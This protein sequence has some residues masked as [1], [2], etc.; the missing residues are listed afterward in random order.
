MPIR[1]NYIDV[2]SDGR[3]RLENSTPITNFSSTSVGSGLLDVISVESEKVYD[4]I[5]T[6]YN[7]LD[8]TKNVGRELDKIGYIVG[9]RRNGGTIAMDM[10]DTNFYFYIDSRVGSNFLGLINKIYP[11]STHYSYRKRMLDAG[12]IDNIDNPTILTIPKN[13]IVHNADQSV[14]YTTLED[15]V[16]TLTVNEAYIPIMASS[17]GEYYNIDSNTLTSHSLQNIISMKDMAPYIKCSN[18][19]PITSGSYSES[20]SDFRYRISMANVSRGSNEASLRLELLSIPGI[21]N[22][23]YERGRYGSGTIGII[24]EGVS[25]LISES[26]VMAVKERAEQVVEGSTVYVSRPEYIGIELSL[27]IITAVGATKSSIVQDVRSKVIAYI[28]D[29][30]LGGTIVWNQL[31]EIIMSPEGVDDFILTFFK[32]GEYDIFNKI[33]KKQVVLRPV[34][35]KSNYNEKFYTDAG[36][37]SLCCVN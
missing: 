26:L 33:N 5:E 7:I 29:L 2:Y 24:V 4:E 27:D 10:T 34:N 28:N 30:P 16:F 35:Q 22:I 18:R 3:K 25:P 32:L 13:T 31:S 6:L 8:P 1:R 20:E 12:Y 14:T 23:L 36:M 15:A 17:S 21:R 37:I 11:K 19:F 9:A